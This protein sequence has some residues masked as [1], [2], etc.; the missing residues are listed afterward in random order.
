MQ[1]KQIDGEIRQFKRISMS[2]A[3][4][5]DALEMSKYIIDRDL[6]SDFESNK[7]I[8]SSLNC[9]MIISYCR[10]FSGNDSRNLIKI[11]DL[12]LK[13]LKVLSPIER[14]MHDYIMQSRNTLLAHSDSQAVDLKFVINEFGSTKMLQPIRNWSLAPLELE[15][16]KIF[17]QMASK[18]LSYVAIERANIE[19][20]IIPILREIDMDLE[21]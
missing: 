17:H 2:F 21:W 11:P 1:G 10:P 3:D 16:L 8:I 6:H 9:S 18:L 12:S 7:L 15:D 20:K 19:P 14:K 4:F 5:K 13:S